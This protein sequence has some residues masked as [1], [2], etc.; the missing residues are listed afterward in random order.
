MLGFLHM[1]ASGV[2]VTSTTQSTVLEVHAPPLSYG[3][4]DGT[5]SDTEHRSEGRIV[6]IQDIHSGGGSG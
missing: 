1:S 6:M 3:D 4:C 2:P 5:E